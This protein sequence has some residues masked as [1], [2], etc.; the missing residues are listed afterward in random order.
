MGYI[1]VCGIIGQIDSV[2]DNLIKN[3]EK[4]TIFVNFI[5]DL[6]EDFD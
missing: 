1:P 3:I 6:K 5:A 2:S 4:F